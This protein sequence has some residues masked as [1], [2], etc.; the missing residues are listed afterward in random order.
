[1]QHF[2]ALSTS[3]IGWNVIATARVIERDVNHK[4]AV[5]STAQSITKYGGQVLYETFLSCYKGVGGQS[6]TSRGALAV[7]VRS[8]QDKPLVC[9]VDWTDHLPP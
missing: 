6:A 9:L 1:M 2:I 8:S 4:Q 7:K 3:N 5:H